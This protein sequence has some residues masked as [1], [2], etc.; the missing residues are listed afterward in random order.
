MNNK[1]FSRFYILSVLGIL[2]AS[3]YPVY[4]GVSVV[5]DMLRFGTVYAESYP[6]YII[7]YT[8]ISI[9]MIIGVALMPVILRYVKRPVPVISALCVVIFFAVELVLE[10]TVIVTTTTYEPIPTAELEAWQMSLCAVQYRE[11]KTVTAVDILMGEYSPA[12]KLHFYLISVVLILTLLNSFYG[13]GHM[14]WSG[15]KTRM[16]ALSL[17]SVSAVI[18]LGLCI[19]ACF[20]AFYRTGTI[21]VSP[22]SAVLMCLFFV[23]FGVTAGI[24]A[25]S[26]LLG[27]GKVLSV[28]VPALVSAGITF[29][30]YIGEMILLSGHL[31]RFGAGF[32][33]EGIPGI[34]LAPIDLLV[35]LISGA[36]AAGIMKTLNK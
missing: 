7:P 15:D 11:F 9:A 16:K 32:F 3:F 21:L 29:A 33:F 8:P 18:F 13:F 20:T 10:K 28:Y 2:I 30:M 23:I 31:Y 14:L 35:I 36:A 17:Q 24:Y 22:V 27:K 12:F 25:G 34:I 26:F 1:A 19:L 6:K 5:S 4:M